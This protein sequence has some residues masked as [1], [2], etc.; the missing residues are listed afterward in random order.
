MSLKVRGSI[1]K[2]LPTQT[3][4]GAKGEWKKIIICCR[5]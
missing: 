5:H 4:Q 1:T 3:G 2:I